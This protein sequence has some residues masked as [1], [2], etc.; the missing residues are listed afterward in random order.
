MQYKN[1]SVIL[2]CYKYNEIS[3][4]CC[5]WNTCQKCPCSVQ[6]VHLVETSLCPAFCLGFSQFL[7]QVRDKQQLTAMGNLE[8]PIHLHVCEL[9]EEAGVPGENLCRHK[10]NMQTHTERSYPSRVSIPGPS[11]CEATV[12]LSYWATHNNRNVLSVLSII[13][14]LSL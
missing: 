5:T 14:S 3:Q 10:E 7:V 2:N 8:S 12:P 4:D 1:I 9:W 13:V 6:D 11:C